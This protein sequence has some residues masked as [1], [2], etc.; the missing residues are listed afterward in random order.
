[1]KIV[2]CCAGLTLRPEA[3]VDSIASAERQL[4]GTATRSRRPP[5]ARTRV[6]AQTT[7]TNHTE[8]DEAR[9]R[10]RAAHM[11]LEHGVSVGQVFRVY[12][13]PAR[14]EIIYVTPDGRPE[15]A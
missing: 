10:L 1:M 9:E 8:R 7:E 5:S 4:A 6:T 12:A 11:L 2:Q 14:R 3:C 13:E 15:T